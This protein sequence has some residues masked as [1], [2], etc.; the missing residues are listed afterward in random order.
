[1]RKIRES[2]I[3]HREDHS[4]ATSSP[5]AREEPHCSLQRASAGAGGC[6]H[7]AGGFLGG[8]VAH[9]DPCYGSLF[10]KDHSPWKR[11]MMK[12]GKSVRRKEWQG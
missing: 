1:M 12:K 11:A 5:E 2:H 6:V 7:A 8:M 9:G 10:L 3:V 4:E